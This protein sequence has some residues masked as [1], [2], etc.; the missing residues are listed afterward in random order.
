MGTRRPS[1]LRSGF[2]G[3]GLFAARERMS[4]AWLK[5]VSYRSSRHELRDR[6]GPVAGDPQRT[7]IGARHPATGEKAIEDRGSQRAGEVRTALGPIEAATGERAPLAGQRGDIDREGVA[8]PPAALGGD[9][10]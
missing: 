8:K 1:F 3:L 7:R 2:G 10:E 4:A 5:S 6:R 9:A